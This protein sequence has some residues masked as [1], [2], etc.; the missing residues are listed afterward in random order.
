MNHLLL[1]GEVISNR[2]D[3]VGDQVV[4]FY[5]N[6]EVIRKGTDYE[7]RQRTF[8]DIAFISWLVQDFGLTDA[9]ASL[10]KVWRSQMNSY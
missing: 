4:T 10:K 6:T 7:S 3:E 2:I 5:R 1:S 8:N 9:L